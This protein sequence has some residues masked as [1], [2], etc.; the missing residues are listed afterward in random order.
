MKESS[1]LLQ[2]LAR[3]L[4]RLNMGIL[5]GLALLLFATLYWTLERLFDEQNS[6]VRLHFAQLM[7]NIQEQELFLKRLAARHSID[8]LSLDAPHHL[9]LQAFPPTAGQQSPFATPFSLSLYL[10]LIHI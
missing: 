2:N 7:E 8:A 10:S 5:L 9:N 6:N 1:T 3:S 4:P